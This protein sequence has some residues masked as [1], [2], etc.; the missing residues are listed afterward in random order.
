MGSWL[1]LSVAARGFVAWCLLPP[2]VQAVPRGRPRGLGPGVHGSIHSRDPSSW[3]TLRRLRPEGGGR[4]AS[5]GTVKG[6]RHSE[7]CRAGELQLGCVPDPQGGPGVCAPS[8]GAQV[9]GTV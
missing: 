8:A 6:G 1:V 4:E 5:E 2:C 3:L 9:R 7:G